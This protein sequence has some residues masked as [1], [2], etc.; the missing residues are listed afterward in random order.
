MKII[1]TT[2]YYIFIITVLALA[3]L[4][5]AS[6]FPVTGNYKVKVVLSGSMEPTLPIGSLIFL[7]PASSYT[8]GDII[9]FGK[10]TKTSVPTTHRIVS[11]RT[12]PTGKVFRTKGDANEDEDSRD[13]L[14]T[15][16]IGR[17]FFDLPYIGYVLDF[18]KKPVGFVLL[19]ILPALAIIFDEITNIWKEVKKR[20]ETS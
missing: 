5:A 18:A 6:L 16:I 11:M 8:V 3:L 20:K 19:V 7:R 17:V 4:L 13:V 15:E 14:Q 12:E 9:T 2:I 1:T 10:D